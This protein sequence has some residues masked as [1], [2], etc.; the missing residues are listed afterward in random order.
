MKQSFSGPAGRVALSGL[1]AALA[2]VLMALGTLIPVATYCAPM[3][4]SLLVLPVVKHCG[5]RFGVLWYFA[6]SL[7]ALLLAPDRE[8]ALIFLLLGYY[9]LLRPA[10]VK[11]PAVPA[12]LCKLA[13]FNGAAAAAFMVLRFLGLPT[14][15]SEFPNASG[16]LLI[17]LLLGF[18]LC[19]NLVFFL[20]DSLIPGLSR[21]FSL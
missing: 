13:V 7:L 11:L 6:V 21:R 17:V 20:Y 3:L 4:A 8:A 19:L 10:L 16:R 5:R 14:I 9:P 1:L 2:T 18:L 12:F 15:L